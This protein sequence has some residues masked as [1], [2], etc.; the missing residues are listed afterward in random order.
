MLFDV[1]FREVDSATRAPRQLPH[2]L[3]GRKLSPR[4]NAPKH[5]AASPVTIRY[6]EQTQLNKSNE[7]PT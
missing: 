5:S 7:T 3:Q 1:K 6:G 4:R 2:T